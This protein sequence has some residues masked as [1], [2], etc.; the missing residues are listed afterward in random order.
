MA[1]AGQAR[2]INVCEHAQNALTPSVH[3]PVYALPRHPYAHIHTLPAHTHHPHA[4]FGAKATELAEFL[5]QR[6][7]A[8]AVLPTFHAQ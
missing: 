6:P 2:Q 3:L 1:H 8:S 4:R 7:D 5:D